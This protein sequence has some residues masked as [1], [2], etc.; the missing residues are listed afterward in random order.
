[1]TVYEQFGAQSVI[2]GKGVYTDL[3]GA[4]ISPAVWAM[5]TEANGLSVDI[6]DL[7]DVTGRRVAEL[8]GADAARV[9]PGASAAISLA[10]A[11]CMTGGAPA[12]IER[13]PD[14][15]GL[16]NKVLIQSGH[17]YKYLRMALLAGA[18]VQYVGGEDGM[19]PLELD[20][21]LA[22]PSVAM[23]FIPAHLDG[24]KSTVTLADAA[25]LARRRE[26][27]TFVDAAYLNYPP[28]SMR[29]F[30]DAGADLVCFSAKYWYGPNSGGIIVGRKDLIDIIGQ[31]DF[32]RF[33]SGN[34]LRFG[35]ALKMD[36][37]TVVG[38]VAALEEWFAMDHAARW[39]DYAQKV[40]KLAAAVEGKS[41]VTSEALCFTMWETLESEPVNCLRVVVDPRW[42]GR[43]A[44]EVNRRLLS[45]NPRILVHLDGESLIIAVDAMPEADVDIVA[46]RLSGAFRS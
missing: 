45:G 27:P 4:T 20:A 18:D 26:I 22:D 17:R 21:C 11:A 16:R 40:R 8:V 23:L 46:E 31:L 2:N 29:R 35:R 28:E 7:L 33:E 12:E 37:F 15:T 39:A 34:V 9:V 10:T 30:T 36:R 25:P 44:A 19:T 3:G 14:T 32:T 42:A 41:G 24:Q 5:M 38:T 13:L 43:S 6:P 1:M